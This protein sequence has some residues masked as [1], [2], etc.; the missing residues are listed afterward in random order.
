MENYSHNIT[1]LSN[2]DVKYIFNT[3]SKYEE[4]SIYSKIKGLNKHYSL[5]KMGDS[6]I[7]LFMKDMAFRK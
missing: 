3:Q 2:K 1:D 6:D 5:V 4:E 7:D